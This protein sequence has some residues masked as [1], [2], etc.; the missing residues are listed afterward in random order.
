MWW[1]RLF[2]AGP[3]KGASWIYERRSTG[4]GKGGGGGGVGGDSGGGGRPTTSTWS[5]FGGVPSGCIGEEEG[6]GGGLGPKSVCTKTGPISFVN[7]IISHNEI[8]VP[9]GGGVG[10]RPRYLMVCLW[11]RLLASRTRSF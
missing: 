10:T 6:E 8:W 3:A 2:I 1:L 5:G 11:R 7:F 9:G 4:A